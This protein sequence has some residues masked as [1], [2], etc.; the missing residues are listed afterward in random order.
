M[1]FIL[2]SL[3][4]A[5]VMGISLNAI[6]QQPADQATAAS[7]APVMSNYNKDFKDAVSVISNKYQS[8]VLIDSAIFAEA[9]PAVPVDA[10]SLSDAL[11]KLATQQKDVNWR[12]VILKKPDPSK[13]YSIE[14]LAS[15]L[16]ALDQAEQ[17]ELIV[18]NPQKGKNFSV[19][20][21]A[22]K[23][24]AAP[25]DLKA[26]EQAGKDVIYVLYYAPADVT[27][28][29]AGQV[30]QERFQ[31]LQRSQMQMMLQMSPD[32][33][34]QSMGNSMKMMMN[35]DPNTRNQFFSSMVK[36]GMQMFQSMT[37]EQRKD[38]MQTMR[39]IMPGRPGGRR[40]GPPPQP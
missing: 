17:D 14:K 13:P 18:L 28:I 38:M 10:S 27:T 6:A 15:T 11:S 4:A 37:P 24:D 29:G 40:G 25:L 34:T 19:T 3:A 1:R 7:A 8:I 12:R 20:G 32:Q 2:A 5:C 22:V 30:V 35:M 31:A 36:G 23:A 26:L 39:D 16:R 33:L 21:Q 9:K